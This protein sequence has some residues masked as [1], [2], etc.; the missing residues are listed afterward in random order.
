MMRLQ[1]DMFSY[2]DAAE[3]PLNMRSVCLKFMA[4]AGVLG[5][6]DC[7]A[8]HIQPRLR[9]RETGILSSVGIRNR[10]I[11]AKYGFEYAIFIAGVAALSAGAG[12]LLAK[13]CLAS[14]EWLI[15][16]GFL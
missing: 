8:Y 3:T 9:R 16:A 5:C 2:L 14:A 4:A 13:A 7:F 1:P 15:R 12:Y 10:S 6:R 11:S